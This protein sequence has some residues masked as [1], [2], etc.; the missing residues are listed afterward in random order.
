MYVASRD[1]RNA[2]NEPAS[3]PMRAGG[4]RQLSRDR[5]KFDGFQIR[6]RR[7]Q[8]RLGRGRRAGAERIDHLKQKR[9]CSG[10]AD[11]SGVS[12]A[13]KISDPDGEDIMI[14][15]RD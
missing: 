3:R 2:G 4:T 7:R 15:N 11:E 1:R 9:G 8:M 10:A 14:E 13:I 6:S 12:A 5:T